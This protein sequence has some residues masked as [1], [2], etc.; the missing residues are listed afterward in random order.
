VGIGPDTIDLKRS[1]TFPIVHGV[2]TLALER[3]IMA[4]STV[5]RVE[6]LVSAG[7]LTEDLGREL[8]SALRV[9]ME[10]RLRSQIAAIRRGNLEGESLVRPG[11]LS[12]T[13]RDILRDALR[14]TRHFREI[15][16]QHYNLQAV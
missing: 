2:R 15:I 9:F 1:G 8:V 4:E 11:D 10:F 5:S 12:S 3:G 7:A 6:A 16:R 13:G 14:V